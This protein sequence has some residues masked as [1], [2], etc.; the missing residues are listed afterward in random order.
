MNLQEQIN[1]IQSMM[2]II[3]ENDSP[4][5]LIE[6]TIK[7]YIKKTLKL[8][9]QIEEFV[10]NTHI[11][12]IF[13]DVLVYAELENEY[14]EIYHNVKYDPIDV[15]GKNVNPDDYDKLEDGRY[16]KKETYSVGIIDKLIPKYFDL[17]RLKENPKEEIQ[18]TYQKLS[19]KKDEVRNLIKLGRIV[20]PQETNHPP[21][22]KSYKLKIK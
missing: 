8:D 14:P 7:E 4:F 1:R 19:E 16:Q 22:A 15:L 13:K 10:P 21:Y 2:G 17:K 18:N 11:A 9:S 20:T 6:K 3:N 12:N 5:N